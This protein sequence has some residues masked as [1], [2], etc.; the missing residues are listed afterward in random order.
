MRTSAAL[1]LALVAALAT[2]RSPAQQ[3]VLFGATGDLASRFTLQASFELWALTG[4]GLEVTAVGRS[5]NTSAA[6]RSALAPE[7]AC[8]GSVF[9]SAG[10]CESALDSFVRT[11]LSVRTVGTPS[12]LQDLCTGL[13]AAAGGAEELRRV[14][15]LGVPPSAV[16]ELVRWLARACA[17]AGGGGDPLR[18]AVILVEKPLGRD[19]AAAQTQ[20][21]A[22]GSWESAGGTVGIVDHYLAKAGATAI[23]AFRAAAGPRFASLWHWRRLNHISVVAEEDAG[24]DHRAAVYEESGGFLR[25]VA[26]NHLTELVALAVAPLR[27]P[28]SAVQMSQ[29]ASGASISAAEV[30]PSTAD[31]APVA[32]AV[33]PAWSAAGPDPELAVVGASDTSPVLTAAASGAAGTPDWAAVAA[34]A[35]VPAPHVDAAART[36]VIRSLRPAM[37]MNRENAALLLGQHE[38]YAAAAAAAAAGSAADGPGAAAASRVAT[39]G[40]VSLAF[41]GTASQAEGP[42]GTV[43]VSPPDLMGV[44]LVIAGG[45]RLG[46]RRALVRLEL[47]PRGRLTMLV[48]GVVPLALSAAEAEASGLPVW[49]TDPDSAHL[50]AWQRPIVAKLNGTGAVIVNVTGPAAILERPA[51]YRTQLA[52]PVAVPASMRVL[53]GGAGGAATAFVAVL[54]PREE[55]LA[56]AGVGADGATLPMDVAADLLASTPGHA[57]AYASIFAEA[58]STRAS[59]SADGPASGSLTRVVS[60]EEALA[61]FRVW[62]P[63]FE[64]ADSEST[65]VRVYAD[66]D[67]MWAGIGAAGTV[68]CHDKSCSLAPGSEGSKWRAMSRGSLPPMLRDLA[69][70]MLESEKQERRRKQRAAE[71]RKQR[72]SNRLASADAPA[73]ADAGAGAAAATGSAD[74]DEPLCVVAGGRTTT[75]LEAFAA[76]RPKQPAELA[77]EQQD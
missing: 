30:N 3:L 75:C 25:D 15:H 47:G 51:A 39:A 60:P 62:D 77:M 22:L 45:K 26:Q 9:K 5:S 58:A 64:A 61:L 50:L 72:R 74:D 65:P 55:L 53:V 69:T 41:S 28:E 57:D 34:A 17:P 37:P 67:T 76:P 71:I 43:E 6:V 44:P 46:K 10:S 29:L 33:L 12:E 1:L 21:E 70:D 48:H 35:T 54:K 52:L 68:A 36:R 11:S 14:F 73:D 19:G 63:V 7:A 16:P 20:L 13:D 66:G 31:S 42:P 4:R 56:E 2:A 27:L 32:A 38:G 8:K 23:T 40:R 24:A 49:P 18:S 59:R